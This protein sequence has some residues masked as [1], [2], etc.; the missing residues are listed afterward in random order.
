[1]HILITG[2]AGYIGSHVVKQLLETTDNRV[3]VIDNLSTGH[4]ATIGTLKKLAPERLGFIQTDLADFKAVETIFQNNA[5]DA[6]IH[7]A[8]SIVVP[9]SV[10]NPLKYYM[11]NT[12]NTTHL[13][14]CCNDYGV[15]RFIFSSTAAVYGEPTEIP[16]KETT[17]KAPINPYGMSKLMSETVL[18]DAARANS[19]FKFVILRYFNVAGADIANRIGQSFPD[20]THLIK[21]AAQTATGAREK[22]FVFGEDYATPDGTCIR[23]YIHVDDLA[24]AHLSALEYLETKKE[25]NIFNC[26][27]GHGFSVK[28]VIDTVKEVSGVNFGVE[29]GPR[30]A[31]DP[32]LLIS[33]NSKIRSETSWTPQYD[34]IKIICQT[35]L[36]WEKQSQS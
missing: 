34:D 23:D 9:E 28:E 3:T 15:N 12:V 21:V 16:V 20:A 18:Q 8:A 30:R 33:D 19:D 32:A 6:I 24:S 27:Y 11:N 1:M 29:T 22:M 25:S 26:G 2:G 17:P 36:A 14:K 4:L 35:A 31:G 7:F 10:E 13:I 5:F